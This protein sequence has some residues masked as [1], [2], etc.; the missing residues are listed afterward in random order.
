MIIEWEKT[1]RG[2]F[3]SINGF[4]LYVRPTTTD[5]W[6]WK[7][8]ALDDELNVQGRAASERAAKDYVLACFAVAED[9]ARALT[10]LRKEAQIER[11]VACVTTVFA[12]VSTHRGWDAWKEEATAAILDTKKKRVLL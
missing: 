3:A 6:T 11:L 10:V 2:Y 8:E 7:L 9:R 4:Y 5:D 1:S 12:S